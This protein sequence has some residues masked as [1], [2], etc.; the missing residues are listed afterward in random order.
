MN[1]FKDILNYKREKLYDKT[2]T[3]KTSLKNQGF[4]YKD[5]SFMAKT[6]SGH[7]QRNEIMYNFMMF[8]D[9][10]IKNWLKGTRYLKRYKNYTVKKD[11]NTTR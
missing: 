10:T 1:I 2:K 4:D 11:D 7:L 9:D 6:T 8:I 5:I 3:R